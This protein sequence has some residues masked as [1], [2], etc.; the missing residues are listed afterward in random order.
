[1][2]AANEAS[3]LATT[4]DRLRVRPYCLP[5]YVEPTPESCDDMKQ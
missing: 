1:M 5:I 3:D 2:Y 4:A